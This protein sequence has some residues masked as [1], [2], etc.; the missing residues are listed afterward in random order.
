MRW[1]CLVMSVFLVVAVGTARADSLQVT[2]VPSIGP[3]AVS[4]TPAA[5]YPLPAGTTVQLVVEL[6]HDD[7]S[8]SDVTTHVDTDYQ[9]LL[10]ASVSVDATGLVTAVSSAPSPAPPAVV[11]MHGPLMA[12]LRFHVSN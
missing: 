10:P 4:G 11:V 3:A 2:A 5:T 9:A 12:T 8:I 7:G 1:S 6:L